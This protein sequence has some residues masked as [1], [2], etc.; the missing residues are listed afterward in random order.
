[1]E[2]KDELEIENWQDILWRSMNT[3][4]PTN[5]TIDSL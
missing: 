3:K 2:T 5:T 1:M 4:R